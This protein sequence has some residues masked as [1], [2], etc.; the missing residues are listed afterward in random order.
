MVVAAVPFL[1]AEQK[2]VAKEVYNGYYHPVVHHF[3]K[4]I[5]RLP[6]VCILAFIITV[7]MVTMTKFRSPFLF[8]VDMFLS[9]F[10]SEA[11][12]QLVSLIVSQYIIGIVGLCGIFG[13]FMLLQGFMLVPSEFPK[14]LLWAYYIPFHTYSWRSF[15][16]L[17]F[18]GDDVVFNSI[19]FPTGMEVLKAY[20]I[21]DVNFIHDMFVLLLYGVILHLVGGLVT[22]MKHGTKKRAINRRMV[23]TIQEN[24]DLAQGT[25][26]NQS[27]F[28]KLKRALFCKKKNEGWDAW[29]NN[30]NI[31]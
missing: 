9:L 21:D 23:E 3:A 16:H 5:A 22:L 1:V 24:N 19:E 25:K 10:C 27:A 31:S 8:F 13:C 2:I 30:T 18:S 6:G 12:A 11:I 26:G 15:M 20:D 29:S 28:V 7:I 4:G 17:E 14:W